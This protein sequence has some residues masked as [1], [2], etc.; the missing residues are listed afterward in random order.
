MPIDSQSDYAVKHSNLY[1]KL[2]YS[3]NSY[4]LLDLNA[5]LEKKYEK[6]SEFIV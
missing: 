4:E 5:E 6:Y 2:G 3:L 1:L